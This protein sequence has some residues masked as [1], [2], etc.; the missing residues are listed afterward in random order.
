M[1]DTERLFNQARQRAKE[2]ALPYAGAVTPPEAYAIL[3]AAPN[4][5]LVDVRTQAEWDWVGQVPGAL[6]IEWNTYPA[7]QRNP[8]FASQLQALAEEKNAPLLFICRSGARSH[9]AAIA[10]AELGYTAAMNVLEGFEGD[11]DSEG[12]R[13]RV[14]GWRYHGLPWKQG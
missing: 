6:K 14:N 11:K 10:A 12:H 7:G 2:Q 3:R 1:D 5:R 4:A 8:Q 13:N 9:A